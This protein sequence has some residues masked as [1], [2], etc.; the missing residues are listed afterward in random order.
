LG[1]Q[2]TRWGMTEQEAAAALG[3]QGLRVDPPIQYAGLYVPLRV[4]VPVSRFSMNAML[5]FS[6][7]TKT[8][9]QVL[10]TWRTDNIELWTNLLDRLTEEYGPSVQ[11]GKFR[12]WRFKTT[13]VELDRWEQEE[14]NGQ[15][16]VRYY[17][18]CDVA[19]TPGSCHP[20]LN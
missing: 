13:I 20:S 19:P 7:M 14:I 12:T 9:S 17:P 10:L 18:S 11:T 3:P 6:D 2:N 1:W 15:V 16:T 4:I 5:Q 8:L